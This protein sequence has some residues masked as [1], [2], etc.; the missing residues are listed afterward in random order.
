MYIVWPRMIP[1]QSVERIQ[2]V[3][4]KTYGFHRL[5][6]LIHQY[7]NSVFLIFQCWKKPEEMNV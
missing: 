6:V 1:S 5:L 4:V 3:L 2:V 7:T